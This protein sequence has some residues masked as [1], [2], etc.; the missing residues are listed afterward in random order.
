MFLT[1]RETKTRPLTWKKKGRSLR[2]IEDRIRPLSWAEKIA[3][4]Q[5]IAEML[6]D[7]PD[8]LLLQ[9]LQMAA[10]TID[11]RYSGPIEAYKAASQL[12][13]LLEQEQI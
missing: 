4:I 7:D 3:L 11:P 10:E 12:Q 1:Q 13:A 2:E 9:R 8:E 5:D 6:H